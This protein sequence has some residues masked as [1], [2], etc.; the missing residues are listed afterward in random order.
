MSLLDLIKKE[1]VLYVLGSKDNLPGFCMN[2]FDL[3]VH[4]VD[5]LVR[6][7]GVFFDLINQLDGL[8]YG[9][10]KMAAE[11]WVALDC[12]MLPSAIVG[13][14]KRVCDVDDEMREKFDI[15][16][17]Y[18]GLVPLT[19]YCA[20]P[21][22]K[23]GVWIVHTLGS[24]DKGKGLGLATKI[25]ALKIYQAQR[26]RVVAQYDNVS[27]RIHS[28]ISDLKLVTALTP[29][30]TLANSTFIY[31][32]LVDQDG[33]LYLLDNKP[34]EKQPSFMLNANDLDVK[35]KM[36]KELENKVADYYVLYPGIVIDKEDP[37]KIQVP[38]KRVEL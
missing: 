37:K 27:L 31:E 6:S 9:S 15:P 19:E 8:S 12:A 13:L 35:R 24:V 18:K 17:N 21:A 16:G 20:I 36:Q 29:A 32:H 5:P 38:M 28:R 3:E 11:K 33:L 14:A 1:Y 25:L 30:H 22:I 23:D 26:I 10:K 7:N 2:P 34:E 4:H